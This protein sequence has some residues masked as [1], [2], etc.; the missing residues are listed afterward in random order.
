M[1]GLRA[2]APGNRPCF[3]EN[4]RGYCVA[5]TTDLRVATSDRRPDVLF[6]RAGDAGAKC[7]WRR[8]DR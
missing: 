4:T 8:A 5:S 6:G 3:A 7:R 2:I 1:P